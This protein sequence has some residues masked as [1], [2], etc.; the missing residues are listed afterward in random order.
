[1]YLRVVRD[2]TSH[3]WDD[4]I[5]RV[6][7]YKEYTF[8]CEII[9]DNNYTDKAIHYIIFPDDKLRELNKKEKEN[10]MVEML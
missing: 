5:V 7:K 10:L 9:V 4:I 2:S 8:D 6:I 1:M 3:V